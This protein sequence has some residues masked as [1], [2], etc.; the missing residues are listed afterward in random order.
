HELAHVVQQ[1]ALPVTGRPLQRLIQRQPTSLGAIPEAERRAI[2]V[3]TTA[4]TVPPERITAFFT[5]M[6]SGRPSES[7]SIGATNSFDPAIP[8]ALHVGLGSIAAYIAGDTNALP[9]NSSIEVDLDLSAHGGAR[10]TYRFTRFS[11]AT[12]T[13]RS[14]STSAV[15]LIEQVGATP[16]AVAAQTVPGNNA[17]AIG[18]GNFS[19]GGNWTDPDYTTLHQALTLLPGASLTAAAGLTFRRVAGGRGPE[20]G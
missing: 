17:F 19:L 18:S 6:R 2:R 9:P 3:G 4:V 8:A 12:G 20:G 7:R 13:W 11:H 14:A 10:T 1:A 5:I 15:M 16:A